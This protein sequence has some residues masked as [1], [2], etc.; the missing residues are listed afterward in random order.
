MF[1]IKH[2]RILFAI[3]INQ[4]ATL[5]LGEG[6]FPGVRVK[7][8]ENQIAG[9]NLL[10]GD[11][12]RDWVD[13]EA[14]NRALQVTGAVFEVNA[15]IEKEL[16]GFI[17]AFEYKLLARALHDASL[18]LSKLELENLFEVIFLEATKDNDLVDPV[19]ELRRKLA[20]C[21]L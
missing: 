16:L 3:G 18:H 10:G 12:I 17:R 1:F 11:Q 5:G 14:L 4:S 21:C 7:I 13:E 9:C 6:E 20:F 15:F 19:H 8:Y 2:L